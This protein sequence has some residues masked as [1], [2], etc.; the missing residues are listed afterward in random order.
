MNHVLS[1]ASLPGS[2]YR[3]A[4]DIAGYSKL[5]VNATK[6]TGT[7]DK[8]NSLAGWQL[9]VIKAHEAL[10]EIRKQHEIIRDNINSTYKPEAAKEQ[11]QPYEEE[12]EAVRQMALKGLTEDLDEV[13]EGKR[14]VFQKS[15]DAPT[16]DQL[17]LLQV[18]SLRD[19]IT[20]AEAG[21]VAGKLGNNLHCQKALAS[22]LR[23]NGISTKPLPTEEELELKLD[24]VRDYAVR[25]LALVGTDK[26]EMNLD[27]RCFFMAPGSGLSSIKFDD[28]DN[29]GFTA[30]QIA[31][32]IMQ[33]A[34]KADKPK[35]QTAQDKKPVTAQESTKNATQ[36]YCQGYESLNVVAAQF[37]VSPEDIRRA[38]PDVNLTN[39]QHG[40]KII[41]PSTRMKYSTV[42][43][44]VSAD[45]CTA[46]EYTPTPV[47]T[48]S[49]G[50]EIKIE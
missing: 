12:L 14:R 31:E 48:Y 47:E 49:E 9:R 50:Q 38:N 22:I 32:D 27:Q 8:A 5:F 26:K 43:G 46:V 17:R 34:E 23:K 21:S 33:E 44:A 30:A 2:A 3:Y 37:G 15:L 16:E 40:T 29:N 7:L 45:S 18:L 25:M 13:L 41:V 19:D 20:V 42:R 24:D 6:P 11:M 39:I 36:I 1:N 10:A 35:D 4:P 28:L